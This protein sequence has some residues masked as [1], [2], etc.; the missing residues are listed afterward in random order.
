M[1]RGLHG[2]RANAGDAPSA[3]FME[4][5]QAQEA[6]VEEPR[7]AMRTASNMARARAA[8]DRAA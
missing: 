2:L 4:E 1:R 3:A 7:A 8:K 6:K 5:I